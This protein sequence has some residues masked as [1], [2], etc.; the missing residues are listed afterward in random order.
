MEYESTDFHA[1][2]SDSCSTSFG[3]AVYF[4]HIR[5]TLNLKLKKPI[6]K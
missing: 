3:Y 4:E 6:K 5:H 1:G 2:E